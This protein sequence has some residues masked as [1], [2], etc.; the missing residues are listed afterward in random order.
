MTVPVGPTNFADF[1]SKGL[2][3]NSIAS[4][5]RRDITDLEAPVTAVNRIGYPCT[6]PF[7]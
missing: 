5:V 2:S 6:D 3:V 4:N 7:M 1:R